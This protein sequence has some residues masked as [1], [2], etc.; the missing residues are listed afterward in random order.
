VGEHPPA[1]KVTQGKAHGDGLLNQ[2]TQ[3]K[4]RDRRL[5]RA[6]RVNARCFEAHE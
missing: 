4:Y 2:R 6:S 3:S 1:Q 5:A